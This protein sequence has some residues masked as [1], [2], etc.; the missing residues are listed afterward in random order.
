MNKMFGNWVA[1]ENE[2]P[3]EGENV[4]VLVLGVPFGAT[5]RYAY[6]SA[7]FVNGDFRDGLHTSISGK[8]EKLTHWCRFPE[9]PA[10]LNL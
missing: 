4:C 10:E 5:T 9:P 7:R 1:V 3:E 6:A 2:L 8:G